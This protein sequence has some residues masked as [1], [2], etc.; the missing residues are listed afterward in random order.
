MRF[1]NFKTKKIREDIFGLIDQAPF[2]EMYEI[3]LKSIDYAMNDLIDVREDIPETN[4]SRKALEEY[5]KHFTAFGEREAYYYQA[6]LDAEDRSVV[7]APLFK[8]EYGGFE[9]D[10]PGWPDIETPWRLANELSKAAA[11]AGMGQDFLDELSQRFQNTITEFWT[12]AT[13]LIEKQKLLAEEEAAGSEPSA[14]NAN[15]GR[16]R[17]GFVLQRVLLLNQFTR[18]HAQFECG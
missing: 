18:H 6:F 1:P 2:R 17:K 8:G 15:G 11:Q 9:F 14:S 7:D 10:G 5:D 12:E 3:V 16:C 13:R 4:A